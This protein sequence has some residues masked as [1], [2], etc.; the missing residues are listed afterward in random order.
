M[1]TYKFYQDTEEN[2]TA[3]C[4]ELERGDMV[5][6]TVIKRTKRG[7]IL[8][9]NDGCEGFIFGSWSVGTVV[10][11]SIQKLNEGFSPRLCVDSVIS[12]P[13]VA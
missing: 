8:S 12:Y 5:R 3:F 13:A 11:A 4:E 6:A 7:A 1:S 9:F 10:W 2:S